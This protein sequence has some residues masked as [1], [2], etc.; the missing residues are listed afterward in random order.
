MNEKNVRCQWYSTRFKNPS[1]N[2]NN[3]Y[4]QIYIQTKSDWIFAIFIFVLTYHH[5][6]KDK[7]STWCTFHE[8]IAYNDRIVTFVHTIRH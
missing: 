3:L 7:L 8:T 5:C 1:F 6:T 2:K 4:I